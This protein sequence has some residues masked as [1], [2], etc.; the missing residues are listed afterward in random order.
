VTKGPLAE[1]AM[2]PVKLAMLSWCCGYLRKKVR[3][4]T[5]QTS[6]ITNLLQRLRVLPFEEQTVDHV[7]GVALA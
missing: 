2:V 3:Y 4:P 7:G 5:K 1:S 6:A